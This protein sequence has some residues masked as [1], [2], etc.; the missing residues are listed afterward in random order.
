MDMD[1]WLQVFTA[2][3]AGNTLTLFF[4]RGLWEFRRYEALWQ[5]PPPYVYV[6]TIIGPVLMAAS[7]YSLS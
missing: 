7:A 6:Y 1:T 4:L 2:V 3:L 5:R